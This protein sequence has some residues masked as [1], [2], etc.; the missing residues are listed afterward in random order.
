MVT[1]NDARELCCHVST[2]EALVIGEPIPDCA[3]AN[4][5]M[6]DLTSGRVV[7]EVRGCRE[8]IGT[9][10]VEELRYLHS[11]R[12]AHPARDLPDGAEGVPFRRVLT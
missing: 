7:G 3:I 11:A 9:H 5:L 8:A 12:W 10:V 1:A 2:C 6:P 4:E